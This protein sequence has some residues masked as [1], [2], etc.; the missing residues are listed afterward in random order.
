MKDYLLNAVLKTYNL[1]LSASALEDVR[2]HSSRVAL[3]SYGFSRFLGMPDKE[4]DEIILLG[5]YHDIGKLGVPDN[6]LLKPSKLSDEE[7]AIM[8]EHSVLGSIYISRFKGYLAMSDRIKHHH[9]RWDGGGYPDGLKATMIPFQSRLISIVDA[10]EAMTSQRC[11]HKA[12][13]S[14]EAIVELSVNAGKQFD[15]RLTRFFQEYMQYIV[16]SESRL[17]AYSEKYSNFEASQ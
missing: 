4:T 16:R 17:G 9:E 3:I 6:I 13:T 2:R 14:Q 1:T 10:F 11:Y 7:F 15:P 12:M 8:K 5:Q